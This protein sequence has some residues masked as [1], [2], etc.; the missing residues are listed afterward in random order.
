MSSAPAA[1]FIFKNARVVTVDRV[2]STAQAVAIAGDR[3]LAVGSD[4]SVMATAGPRTAVLD[5][6]G[7]SV[8]PG[9]CDS[10]VHSYKASVSEWQGSAPVIESLAGAFEYI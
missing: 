4:S 8:L 3:I 1:D 5:A 9:L 2:F 6:Q 10:H 7:R